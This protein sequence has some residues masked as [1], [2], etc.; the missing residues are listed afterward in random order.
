MSIAAIG[1]ILGVVVAN[2]APS[3][4]FELLMQN[5]IEFAVQTNLPVCYINS[6]RAENRRV[7]QRDLD[8]LW[9]L[10]G[11]KKPDRKRRLRD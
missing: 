10:A 3:Q 2:T 7:L 9:L 11:L 5:A 4:N 8:N 1:C 6:S